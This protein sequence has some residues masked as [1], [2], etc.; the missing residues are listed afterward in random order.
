MSRFIR[1]LFLLLLL[2]SSTAAVTT[3]AFAQE[4]R[5]I[6]FEEAVRI[7]LD[8]N[9]ALQQTENSVELESRQVFQ[10]RMDFLPNLHFSTNGSR[11]SGFWQDQAG[12]NVAFTNKNVNGSL[13]TN[14]NLFNCFAD[15]ASLDQANH[16]REWVY[17]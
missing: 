17:I 9:I 10:Q 11:G 2:A 7:A 16:E 3:P 8:Q 1:S 12:R 5:T 14:V 4:I 15:V 6:T 13:S